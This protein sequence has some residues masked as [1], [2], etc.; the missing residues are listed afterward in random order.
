MRLHLRA[1][2]SPRT[3]LDGHRCCY[4]HCIAPATTIMVAS[5]TNP[6]RT[7]GYTCAGI[8]CDQHARESA[9]DGCKTIP[10]T[11]G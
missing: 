6:H 10:L 1:D 7:F 4:K 9:Q 8:V 5:T 3:M 11:G 2:R